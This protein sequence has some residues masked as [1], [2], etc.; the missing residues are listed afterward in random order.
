VWFAFL[1]AGLILLVICGIY[2][3]RRI[4]AALSY[5]AVAQWRIRLVR[6]LMAWL[7]FGFPMIAFVSIG[8]S[9]LL[10]RATLPRYDSA[11]TSWLLGFPWAWAL[12]VVLQSL[13]WLLATVLVYP[14]VHRRRPI[15]SATRLRALAVLAIVG[16]FAFYTPLRIFIER[17]E[18]R[19]RHHQL[20]VAV[21]ADPAPF[22]I[23]FVADIQQDAN[24]TAARAR[25]VY[26]RINASEPDVVLSG[27]DW[28][29]S[30]PEYIESAAAAAAEL[31]SRLGTFSVRGDHEHFAYVDRERSV[32]EIEQ[33]MHAHGVT[34]LSDQVRWF[35]HHG[36][37]IAV[38]F[39][40]YNYIH[41]T[42]AA[43]F[44]LLLAS[45]AD[46][47]YKI[48]ITHQLDRALADML[49]GKVNLVLAGHTHGGQ[50]NPVIGLTHANL[51]RLETDYVD[52][53]YTRGPTTIIV[54][55]G[56]GFSIVP[57]RYA[58]PGSIELID[59]RL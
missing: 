17:G 9:L 51:A 46:A 31:Q 6:W 18:L 52:G 43:T 21:P 25:D 20:G 41:R 8:I 54:T 47:D 13:P 14:T 50:V 16:A 42:D 40:D 33:A 23:A 29:N 48:A 15:A 7:L 37:R 36:K 26:A 34:M 10:G 28:I 24:T 22:R 45:I 38:A 1:A 32:E 2:A 4:T 56:V 49:A 39:L 12:L 5:F 19:V 57:F 30:G 11:I 27:G 58:A 59:L 55:A 35:E 53:R 3:M 44:S